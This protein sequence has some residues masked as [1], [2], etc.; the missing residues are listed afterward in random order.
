MTFLK[1]KDKEHWWE[2]GKEK[3]IA[4]NYL[5][6]HHNIDENAL[7]G[8]EYCECDSWHDL[9]LTKHYCP[10]EVTKREQDV[11]ISPEGK[12]YYGEAH[13]VQAEH[14]CEIIYGLD[15]ARIDWADDY[16]IT[17]GWIKATTSLMWQVSYYDNL[18]NSVMPQAQFDALWDWCQL[19]QQDFPEGIEVV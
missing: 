11:W 6:G 2:W 1:Y 17:L 8:A 19:H 15:D 16:L 7:G 4:Y 18:C 5:G 9:Y 3:M 13:A 14:L 12:Y 10:L